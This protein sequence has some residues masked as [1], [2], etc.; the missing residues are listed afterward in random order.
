MDEDYMLTTYD[1][2]FNPFTNFIGWWKEDMR[3]GWNTC[4][5]LALEAQTSNTFSDE[6]N[7]KEIDRAMDK[8]VE[9]FPMIFR[10]VKKSDFEK[11]S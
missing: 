9:D 5:R 1:N 7:E 4:G 8:I 10:K 6:V 11:A 3:L 2:K